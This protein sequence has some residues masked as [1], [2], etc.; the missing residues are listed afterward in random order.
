[1]I[2]KLYRD[3]NPA[4]LVT[5]LLRRV[6]GHCYA[7]SQPLLLRIETPKVAPSHDINYCIATHPMARPCARAAA[8]PCARASLVV[9]LAGRVMGPCRK[10]SWPYRGPLAARPCALCH[11][12]VC[13]IMTQH[14]PKM[15]SSPFQ[16]PLCFAF[17][18]FSLFIFHFLFPLFLLLY[19][20]KKIY[21]F[22]FSCLK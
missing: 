20:H 2:Q 13:C 14:K 9:A 1:M 6:A 10:A 12:T 22:F 7:V 19:D 15:G 17:F 3:P 21:S 5:A 18:F 4:A 8:R 11:D 16:S